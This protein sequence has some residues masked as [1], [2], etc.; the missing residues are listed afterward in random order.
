LPSRP[1]LITIPSTDQDLATHA[2]DVLDAVPEAVP[3]E[4]TRDLLQRGLQ[5]RYPGAVVRPRDDLAEVGTFREVVWYVTHRA[6]RSR[7]S[8]SLDI[9]APP[10]Y[11]FRT[12]VERVPEWQTAVRLRP[13][14]LTPEWA[15]SEWTATWEFL[16]RR[17]HGVFRIIEADAP[18]S[19]RFEASGLGMIRVWYDTSFT[20]SPRGTMVR[21]VGDYDL[22]DGFLPKM[23]DRLFV[24]RG[25][26]RQIDGAHNEL[27]ALCI[28]DMAKA[29]AG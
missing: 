23:V 7:I 2:Q 24:E 26:Q 22:P 27:K 17:V 5:G 9:P 13:R 8:A 28:R 11:V 6:F 19:V 21:V 29:A 3:L 20:P 18:Y 12:Y 4:G 25:I 1:R 14:Y 15:G 10:D 16:G